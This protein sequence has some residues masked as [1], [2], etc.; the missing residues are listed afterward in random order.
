[1][2]PTPRTVLADNA[3]AL[4]L[5]GTRTFLVGAERVAIID[6]GPADAHH[7]DGI[8][9]ALGNA[10]VTAVL[11]THGHPDHAAAGP[12]LAERLQAPLRS[13]GDGSLADGDRLHTD[14]GALVAIAT[15][16]HTDDHMAFHWPDA[17]AVFVGD[18]FTGGQDTSLVAPPEGDL[19]HYLDSLERIRDLDARILYPTHGPAFDNPE[20]AID[21]YLNHRKLRLAQVLAALQEGPLELN[22]LVD[23][24]Y[25]AAL[26]PDLRAAAQGAVRAYLAYLASRG[27]VVRVGQAWSLPG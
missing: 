16:G 19:A 22:A 12:A 23:T 2:G 11:L 14:Q 13:L 4:T 1:M 24:V 6:P 15:P 3:S 27:H 25:G 20:Q 21:A 8:V 18:L 9:S 5:D 10:A 7:M 17:G 26:A